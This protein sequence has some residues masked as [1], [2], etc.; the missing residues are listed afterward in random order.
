MLRTIIIDDELP[1]LDW[2]KRLLTGSGS[3]EL[4]GVYTNPMDALEQL[5]SEPIDVVFLDIEMPDIN[6]LEFSGHIVEISPS[7]DIVFVTAYHQYALEAFERHAVDYVLKPASPDRIGATL[8]KLAARRRQSAGPAVKSGGAGEG[9]R[10]FGRFDWLRDNEPGGAVKW[11]TTKERELAAF[12]VHNGNE[13]VQKEKIL[14]ALWGQD[15]IDQSRAY[16]Y[17]CIYTLR[18]KL[19]AM[20]LER[21]LQSEQNGYR[22]DVAS[23][24]CDAAEF[25]KVCE[26]EQPV[27]AASIAKMVRAVSLYRGD[28]LE[29]D[30]YF[31]AMQ[32]QERYRERYISL[33]KRMAAYY[34]G[35]QSYLQA[36]ECL[37]KITDKNPFLDDINELMIRYYARLGDRLSMIRHYEKFTK[38]L[39]QELGIE[40]LQ[41]TVL[42]YE[43]LRSG[44]SDD[45]FSL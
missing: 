13:W 44:L 17:T 19:S 38:Q 25:S 18:K 33:L 26:G 10:C 39:K 23:I 45:T 21:L 12:L 16:L 11:R 14:D 15:H 27:D 2:M 3:V 8:A 6:G 4:A 24:G 31:W 1:A 22:L 40:P 5:G 20:G 41:R 9:I 42:L 35:V 29:E 30:G 7:T 32:L 34:A 36:I 28:Y 37:R 43:H